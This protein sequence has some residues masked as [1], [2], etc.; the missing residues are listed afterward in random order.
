MIVGGRV[1]S[2]GEPK[3]EADRQTCIGNQNMV[4]IAKNC[5]EAGVTPVID[6]I[7]PDDTQLDQFVTGLTP[8]PVWLIVLDPGDAACTERNRHRE[9]G[10][11]FHDHDGLVG[12]MRR[13]YGPCAWWVS[14]TD[15]TADE[16]FRL[17]LDRS[18][19]D[20]GC[21]PGP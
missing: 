17:I 16:T 2:L 4:S 8:L 21:P 7:I 13:E 15:Q 3:E 10:F 18:H 9:D 5:A 14:S 11:D 6:W 19:G 1:C 20:Q 12:G